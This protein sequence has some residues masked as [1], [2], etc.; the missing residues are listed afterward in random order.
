MQVLQE[1]FGKVLDDKNDEISH[2]KNYN[3]SM[4]TQNKYFTT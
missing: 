2:L 3:Q 1:N 4:L